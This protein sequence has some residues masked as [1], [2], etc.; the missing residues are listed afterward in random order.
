MGELLE[1]PEA[2]PEPGEGEL[3]K[4]LLTFCLQMPH[5]AAILGQQY[6]C[7]GFAEL[8]LKKES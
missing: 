5:L 2:W 3:Y 8:P 6:P 7:S 1:K 4:M